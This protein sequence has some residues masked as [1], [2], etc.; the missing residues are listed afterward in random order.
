MQTGLGLEGNPDSK[1]FSHVFSPTV[2]RSDD[3]NSGFV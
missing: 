3:Y 2:V 1:S